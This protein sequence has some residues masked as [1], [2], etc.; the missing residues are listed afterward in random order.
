M[1]DIPI[2]SKKEK[3]VVLWV[4]TDP[5]ILK[6]ATYLTKNGFYVK[7]FSET[8]YCIQYVTN[9]I[10]QNI[11]QNINIVGVITSMMRRGGRQ[12]KKLMDGLQMLHYI[13]NN[14]LSNNKLIYYCIVSNSVSKIEAK[15]Y[16]IDI[17]I[18]SSDYTNPRLQVQIQL[19][20]KYYPIP[21]NNINDISS[22]KTEKQFL[23][24][25]HKRAK[26]TNC[27]DIHLPKQQFQTQ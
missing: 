25:L 15:H 26:N 12:K 27:P 1:G 3:N 16:N 18:K 23:E 10:K 14:L 8:I 11:K 19:L 13:K 6:D 20:L 22:E 7:H 5:S 9:H 21:T 4:D 2:I 17:V 24:M